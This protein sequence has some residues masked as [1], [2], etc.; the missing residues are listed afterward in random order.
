MWLRSLV[1]ALGC[2]AVAL[3]GGRELQRDTVEQRV[4]VLPGVRVVE[5]R[6]RPAEQLP[7]AF[8]RVDAVR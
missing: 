7:G 3:G 1:C 5:E 2:I 8:Y 6:L 4:Y